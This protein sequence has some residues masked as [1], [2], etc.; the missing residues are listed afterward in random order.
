MTKE[1]GIVY[2]K[3]EFYLYELLRPRDRILQEMERYAERND[4]PIIGPLAGALLTTISSSCKAKLGLEIGTAIGYSGILLGRQIAENS[5]T[6]KLITIERDPK[7][8]NLA[9]SNFEKAGLGKNVEIIQGD[10]RKVVPELSRKRIGE[11]DIILLDVGEK[12]LYP[13]LLDPCVLLLREG[14]FLLADNILWRGLV[15]DASNKHKETLKMRKFNTAVYEEKRLRP[16]IVPLR[17]GVM[18]A[19][20][21]STKS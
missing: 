18:V 11:F 15:A 7:M 12:T 13:E 20:K 17:D 19:E 21:V 3:T 5:S 1:I 2:P 9:Q 4:V 16:L 14:G 8:R 6:G 10:A